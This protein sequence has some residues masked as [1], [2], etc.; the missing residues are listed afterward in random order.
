MNNK[1]I[2]KPTLK[3]T[4]CLYQASAKEDEKDDK[5]DK[6]SGEDKDKAHITNQ[7]QFK[8]NQFKSNESEQI[9][10]NQNNFIS[11]KFHNN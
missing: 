9:Q 1:R 8:S 3:F 7:I 5:K 4:L 2:N 6:D 11:N 10:K